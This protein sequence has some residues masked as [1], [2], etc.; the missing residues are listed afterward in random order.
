MSA[1]VTPQVH[2]FTVREYYRLDEFGLFDGKRVELIEGV[3][4]DKIYPFEPQ[5]HRWT[6]KEYR[7]MAEANLFEGRHVE[8]IDGEVI[9]MAAMGNAHRTSVI[10]AGDLLRATF[11]KGFFVSVQCPFEVNEVSE[12]EPDVAVIK[13]NPRQYKDTPL[14]TAVLIVE[15]ADTSLKY[16]RTV[17]ASIYAAAGMKDYWIINLNDRRLKVYRKPIKDASQPLGFGYSEIRILTEADSIKP[18]SAKS[19]IAIAELLP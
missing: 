8:L 4:I 13:G 14:T 9:E 2:R 15:V 17:K 1:T 6:V 5:P 18:L 16:D 19:E 11:G 3:V 12:P 10:L 7:K